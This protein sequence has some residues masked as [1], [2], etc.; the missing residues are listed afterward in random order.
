MVNCFYSFT[1]KRN[2]FLGYA[3]RGKME[4]SS[5]FMEIPQPFDFEIGCQYL[6]HRLIG[7]THMRL[8][9]TLCPRLLELEPSL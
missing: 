2:Q 3:L 5:L 4:P 7:R 9:W 8:R 1:K 6:I